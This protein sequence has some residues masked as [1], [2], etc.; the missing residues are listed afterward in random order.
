MLTTAEEESLVRHVKNRSR[1]LQGMS[2]KQVEDVVLSI[3]RTREQ[4]NKKG[5]RRFIALSSVAKAALRKKKVSRSFFIRLRT[6]YPELRMKVPRKVDINRGFNVTRE[7]ATE[8]LD[9][10]AAEVNDAGIGN[11]VEV[12]LGVWN[13]PLDPTRIIVHDE[14]PQFINHGDSS[15]TTT[16]VFEVAGERCETLTKSNPFSNI[17]GDTLCTQV[18]FS[19]AGL[20]S[21]MAPESTEKIPNLLVTVNKSGVSDHETLLAAYNEIDRALTEK[22]RSLVRS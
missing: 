12:E 13:G 5:G 6:K 8:Y 21:Q 14:T 11:L 9:D 16:N 22:E 15:Y 2:Q 1:C 17:A 4:V 18:I 20:T 19:G 3:L 7:M 10:L